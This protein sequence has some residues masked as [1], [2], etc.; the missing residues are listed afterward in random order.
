M[1]DLSG[2]PSTQLG[3]FVGN[4]RPLTSYSFLALLDARAFATTSSNRGSPWR[5]FNSGS[6]ESCPGEMR[7]FSIAWF[8]SE[9]ASSGRPLAASVQAKLYQASA[10]VAG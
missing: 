2:R 3:S 6:A 10:T 4:E 5:D 9:N 8:R 1:P 7:P